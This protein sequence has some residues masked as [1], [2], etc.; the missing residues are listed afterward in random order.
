MGYLYEDLDG[1]FPGTENV[2]DLTIKEATKVGR[3]N[4]K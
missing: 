4:M 2:S 1:T 3:E